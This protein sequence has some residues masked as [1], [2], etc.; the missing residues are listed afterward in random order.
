MA[1]VL[2]HPDVRLA[3]E[4]SCILALIRAG[5]SCALIEKQLDVAK[6]LA[7]ELR[8]RWLDWEVARAAS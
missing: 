4:G 8:G 1:A 3:D 5:F 2:A 6:E 7:T